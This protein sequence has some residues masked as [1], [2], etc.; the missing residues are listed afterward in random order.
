MKIRPVLKGEKTVLPTH[1]VNGNDPFWTSGTPAP[2]DGII[3]NLN[4]EHE[5]LAGGVLI[6]LDKL[7]YFVGLLERMKLKQRTE[8]G[9][10]TKEEFEEKYFGTKES[11]SNGNKSER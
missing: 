5:Q 1:A 2:A 4:G 9:A 8:K 3:V 7:K 10:M 6:P 11:K